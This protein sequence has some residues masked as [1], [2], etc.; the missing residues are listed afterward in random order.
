MLTTSIYRSFIGFNDSDPLSA[1]RFLVLSFFAA[2]LLF[3]FS[4][5]S[6][7]LQAFSYGTNRWFLRVD[8]FGLVFF[9]EQKKEIERD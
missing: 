3:N 2:G 8:F 1:L 4:L 5:S 9:V 6:V 7:H